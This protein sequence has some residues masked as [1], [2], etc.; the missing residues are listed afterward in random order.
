M[1]GIPESVR[2]VLPSLTAV[3]GLVIPACDAPSTFD[4]ASVER[5]SA[6]PLAGAAL[7]VEPVTRAS[8]QAELWRESRPADAALME[9]IASQPQAIWLN[10]DDGDAAFVQ[11]VLAAARP[12]VPTFVLYNIPERDCGSGGAP[13]R[14]AYLSWLDGIADAL[15]GSR[16]IAVLEPDALAGATCLGSAGAQRRYDLLAEA[17]RRLSAAGVLT[18]LDAG[19]PRWHDPEETVRRLLAAGIYDVA[20]FAVNVANSVGVAEST[21]WGSA[22]AEEVGR[23]FVIDVGRSGAGAQPEWCNPPHAALGVAPR[24]STEGWVD[25][26]LWIKRPGE[27]DGHCNGGPAGGVWW[28]EYA[29]ALVLAA[30]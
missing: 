18:Y 16:A 17:G 20:G 1:R 25:A 6:N 19:H 13:D 22:I 26:L 3:V 10:G 7:Y 5:A 27:S 29:L 30:A 28:P 21:E 4:P 12:R 14:A 2:R 24:T 15:R 23:G 11:G 9:R 8:R